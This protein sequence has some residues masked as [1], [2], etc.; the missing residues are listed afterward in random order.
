[1]VMKPEPWGE[2]LAEVCASDASCLLQIRGG[3]ER[4]R[5]PIGAVHLAEVLAG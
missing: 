5:S 3:L 2:A 1:M 4:R